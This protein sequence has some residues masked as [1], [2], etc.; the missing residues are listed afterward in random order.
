MTC[1]YVSI[2][3][4]LVF[5]ATP[6]PSQA[7]SVDFR[8]V[9]SSYS[10]IDPVGNYPHNWWFIPPTFENNTLKFPVHAF[11]DGQLSSVKILF[12]YTLKPVG[13]TS[14]QQLLYYM[15]TNIEFDWRIT[16]DDPLFLEGEDVSEVTF[17][18]P[19]SMTINGAESWNNASSFT[20]FT[21]LPYGCDDCWRIQNYDLFQAHLKGAD[22]WDGYDYWRQGS[23]SGWSRDYENIYGNALLTVSGMVQIIANTDRN[24]WGS[25]AVSEI[26]G[27][28]SIG[29]GGYSSFEPVVPLPPAFW[30]FVSGF[31]G[32]VVIARLRSQP[33]M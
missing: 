28:Y 31:M 8:V 17:G 32:I 22:S 29:L 20:D 27:T 15:D 24:A 23:Y 26:N 10:F 21:I 14:S 16:A 2:W 3:L 13:L 30:L 12:S 11:S 6:I 18:A 7:Y 5:S 4:A 33:Q 19:A 1:R 9:D 25:G